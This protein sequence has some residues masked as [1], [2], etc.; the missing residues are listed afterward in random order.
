MKDQNVG[1]TKP[2]GLKVEFENCPV[3]ASLGTLGRKWALLVL[4]NI[5]LYRKQR[6]NEMLNFT[7]GLTQRVLAMRLRELQ[8]DG[9]IKVVERGR[10]HSKWDLTEKG[11]D[12]LPALMMLVQ[13]GSKWH[14]DRVFSDGK[15][16]KL[17]DVFDEWYIRKIMRTLATQLPHSVRTSLP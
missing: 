13:F 12:V 17:E 10:N 15:P 1:L 11:K 16:R 9:F 7:P 5:G 3:Q 6:F 2:I 8:R 4:R 14:A